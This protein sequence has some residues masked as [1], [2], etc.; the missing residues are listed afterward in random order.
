MF[1][2]DSFQ[3]QLFV[4]LNDRL[5]FN[6]FQKKYSITVSFEI[7]S[8]E[9]EVSWPHLQKRGDGKVIGDG[10]TLSTTIG[11]HRGLEARVQEGELEKSFETLLGKVLS[12]ADGSAAVVV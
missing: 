1:E 4:K 9:D 2:I 8:K 11:P 3:V 10:P 5:L 12:E 6:I 7:N